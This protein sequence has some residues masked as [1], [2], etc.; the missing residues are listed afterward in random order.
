MTRRKQVIIS[1]LVGGLGNQMFQYAAGRALALRRGSELQLDV[2]WLGGPTTVGRYALGSF[3]IEAELIN[4]Y[5][6]RRRERLREIVGLAPPVRRHT[7]FRFDSTILDLPGRVRLVGYWQSEKYFKEY[8]DVIRSEFSCKES[9]VGPNAVTAAEIAGSTAVCVHVRRGDYVSDPQVLRYH[10]VLPLSYYA[11][12]AEHV[13]SSVPHA[14]F[15]VFSDDLNWCRSNL[16]LAG[17]MTFV[18]HKQNRA[19]DDLRLMTLCRHHIIANS[20]FSWWGAWLAPGHDRIVIAPK[21]WA[22]AEDVGPDLIPERWIR[23]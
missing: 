17:P 16:R 23:L 22:A 11:S 8:E 14:H 12:A 10:G 13:L 7:S 19:S 21:Q 9:L 20:S 2:G 18:D 3:R 15:F 4:A 5:R 6:H 1:T